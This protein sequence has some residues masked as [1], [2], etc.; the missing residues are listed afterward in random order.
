MA[1]RKWSKA[2]LSLGPSKI[3]GIGCYPDIVIRKGELVRVFAPEDSR[4]IPLAKANASPH[5]KVI[6]RFG[7]R[8]TGG[9]W[10]PIDFLRI[11][12]GWYMNHSETPNL[13]SDDGDVSYFALEDIRPGEEVT[14]DYRRMDPRH[15]N[16]S[17]D[18]VLPGR[19]R[20]TPA[21]SGRPG[22]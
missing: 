18:V 13:Q 1:K 11:S 9:Y 10:A 12:V 4:W 14:M 21:A 19:R 5:R 15:D 8:T 17:R 22:R 20:K 6:K 7:I 16:L 3:H 2:L